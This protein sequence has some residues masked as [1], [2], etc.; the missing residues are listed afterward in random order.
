MTAMHGEPTTDP[1]EPDDAALAVEARRDPAAFDRLYRRYHPAIVRYCNRRL[2]DDDRAAEAAAQVFAKAWANLDRFRGGG[3]VSFRAWLFAIANR[4]VT[5]EH[6]RR[7]SL[8]LDRAEDLPEANVTY[9][10]GP[11]A[12]RAERRTALRSA[13]ARLPEEQ[14]RIV[15]LRLSGLDGVEIAAVL[16]RSHAAIKSSQ[17]RAYARLRELLRGLREE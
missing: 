7:P 6:R 10:P 2:D 13:L 9:L 15:E 11:A 3:P 14:R 17:F 1:D 12:E 5:D 4:T 8:P 16:G